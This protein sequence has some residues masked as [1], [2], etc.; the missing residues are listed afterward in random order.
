MYLDLDHEYKLKESDVW[1]L[2]LIEP[3]EAKVINAK[4]LEAVRSVSEPID[5]QLRSEQVRETWCKENKAKMNV[6]ISELLITA[7]V[8]AKYPNGQFPRKDGEK[9]PHRWWGEI[10][11]KFDDHNT[12]IELSSVQILWLVNDVWFDDTVQKSFKQEHARYVN[13][14]EEEMERIKKIAENPQSEVK[15]P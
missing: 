9:R 15:T 12:N 5:K 11:E 13:K 2:G 14:L 10:Q 7:A 4:I 8:Q 1:S 6:R 3:H